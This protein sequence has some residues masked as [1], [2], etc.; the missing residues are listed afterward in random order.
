MYTLTKTEAEGLK[1]IEI[2]NPENKSKASICLTQGGRLSSLELD[3]IKILADYEPSTYAANYASSILFPFVNRIRD[4][5]YTFEDID[6]VLECNEVDKNNALH[7]LVYDKTFEC[8]QHELTSNH[9]SITLQ[10]KHD[11]TCQG[12]SF[13]FDIQLTYTLTEETIGLSV[14]IINEDDK[15]FPFTIGWHPYFVSKNLDESSIDFDSNTQYLFDQ[16]Q[17]ISGTTPLA[18]EMPYSLKGVK[19]DDGY[20]LQNNTIAFLT[21]EYRLTM[22]STSQQNYLQLYTPNTP[23]VIAIE[24]MTGAADSFNNKLGLQKLN[25]KD[26][27]IV[28]WNITFE[29][30]MD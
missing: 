5:K 13:K 23:N 25:P 28:K 27:Y 26:R 7:G 29:N 3:G 18:V 14:E 8:I 11:G 20:P 16:Q 30:L 19:L 12:F 6:H 10:Y 17:T 15:T 21:P 2:F 22:T 24:P 1:F 4:G 9:G